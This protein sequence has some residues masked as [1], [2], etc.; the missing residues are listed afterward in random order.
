MKILQI[1]A[2]GNKEE[3]FEWNNWFHIGN[4]DTSP[5]SVHEFFKILGGSDSSTL[6]YFIDDDGYNKILCDKLTETPLFAV[7]YGEEN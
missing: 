3:G 5:E 6:N 7:C 4:T 1:D 2:W